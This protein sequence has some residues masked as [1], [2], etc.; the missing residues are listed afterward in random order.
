MNWPEDLIQGIFLKRYKRFFADVQLGEEIVV[1][2]VP[3]TGSMKGVLDNAGDQACWLS[4][5]KDPHRKLRYTLEAVQV[6]SGTW[7][8][9]NTANPNKLVHQL[10][11]ERKISDWQSFESIKMEVKISEHT[12]LDGCL[13]AK[14]GKKRFIEIKNVTLTDGEKTALFPD[15]VTERG[16]KHLLEMMSLIEQGHQSEIIFVVQRNDVSFFEAAKQI[17]PDYARLLSEFVAKQ[18]IVRVLFFQLT[19]MNIEF[20]QELKIH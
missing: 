4:P 18:G 7:V 11:L 14:D 13:S 20:Y 2:H 6:S 1:A 5:A 16:Q 15:A 9:V 17:D 12:R 8:G 3:N 19:K 10:F